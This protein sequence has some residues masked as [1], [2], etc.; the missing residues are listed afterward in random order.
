MTEKSKKTEHKEHKT[1]HHKKINRSH[2][3]SSSTWM[4]ISIVLA[5][6]LVFSIATQGFA[7][8]VG[9]VAAE[10]TSM[11]LINVL[12]KGQANA[13][14][15]NVKFENGLYSMDVSIQGQK[16]TSYLTSDGKV[17]F[18][19]GIPVPGT[20]TQS[21]TPA[22]Q[23]AQNVPKSDK[24]EVDL[25][26]MAYCPYG[27]QAEKGIIPVVEALGNKIDFKIK[28]VDYSMHG[29]KEIKEN[30][31]QVCIENEQADKYFD[32]LSCFLEA[33][34][35]DSC[36]TK[37]GIDTTAMDSCVSALDS[38]YDIMK[39]FN[40]KST[41]MNGQFPQFNV[42]KDENQKYGVQGSPTLVINGQKASSGR[43]P[44]AFLKT[45]CA[46]FN[47]APDECK[48]NLSSDSPSP[49]FG[50]GTGSGSTGSCS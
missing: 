19:Q 14:I 15:D 45:I 3:K 13:T 26:V 44:A 42:Y 20:E 50:G 16:I 46:A 1:I 24:P 18:P 21:N 12:T 27:T 35:S 40:D 33:G 4:I 47:N 34:D 32:Y 23:P 41:W 22:Q 49:G 6:I 29:E 7:T 11:N 5:V 37:A 2:S 25:Y 31:R 10:K 38:K 43:S 48:E 9:K 30:M 36:L 8:K 17:F 39:G 28:F